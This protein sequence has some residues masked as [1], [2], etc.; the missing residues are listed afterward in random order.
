MI[1]VGAYG[2]ARHDCVEVCALWAV[3]VRGGVVRGAL[4]L[5][6]SGKDPGLPGGC[7]GNSRVI[8]HRR[9]LLNAYGEG[10]ATR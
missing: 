10:N 4:P 7:T 6:E 3:L 8:P 2:D 1:R 9:L 5:P